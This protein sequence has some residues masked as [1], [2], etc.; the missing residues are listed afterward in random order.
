MV[1]APP[2]EVL[3]RAATLC[4]ASYSD[5]TGFTRALTGMMAAPETVLL[6]DRE[7]C[8]AYAWVSGGLAH[9]VFRGT[10]DA[11][12]MLANL[13][14]RQQAAFVAGA[15]VHSGFLHRYMAVRDEA[16][17]FFDG[18]DF[19]S[20]VV[21]GH[22]LG[23]ALATI[24]AL[25]L[26]DAYPWASVGCV[27]FGAP[28][29]GNATFAAHFDARLG[30]R[31]WR[32]FHERDPVPMLPMGPWYQHVS[33]IAL[34]V[35][36]DPRAGWAVQK[37]DVPWWRRLLAALM[38]LNYAAPLRPH[39]TESYVAHAMALASKAVGSSAYIQVR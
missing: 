24:A 15:R 26:A 7:A 12:D 6:L 30:A 8:Q 13:D 28:R 35:L 10:D 21:T 14:T 39:G 17:H 20:L 29:V 9:L 23:G 22:S 38:R 4:R 18:H 11:L 2:F 19:T 5:F 27:T 33:G 3:A 31:H 34:R 36:E 37:G 32:V 25:D 1:H 16:R